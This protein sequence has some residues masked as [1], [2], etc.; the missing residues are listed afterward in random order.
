[1]CTEV[2]DGAGL[3]G[4]KL[5]VISGVEHDLEGV[6]GRQSSL[7]FHRI[8]RFTCSAIDSNAW[9]FDSSRALM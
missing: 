4:I 7:S 2:C 1:M 9:F 8:L 3:C 6:N 5:I